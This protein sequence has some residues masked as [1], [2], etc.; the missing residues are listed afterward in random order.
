MPKADGSAAAHGV[1]EALAEL[2]ASQDLAVLAT[3]RE[4]Q[5]YCS[6]VGFAASPDLKGLVF[7][8]TR[9]TRKFENLTADPRVAM[10]ID[11]RTNQV[12][13]FKDVEALTAVG[14]A[15]EISDELKSGYLRGYLEKHPSL[16][17]F[18]KAPDCALMNIQV[19]KYILVQ[20][21]QN[22]TEYDVP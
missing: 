15:E 7:A 19:T 20:H 6:L 22:I 9:S 17:G 12:N 10:M 13:D 16:E 11:S 14:S 8:T 5:P 2:L 4:G 21:F 18:A 1:R 3:H